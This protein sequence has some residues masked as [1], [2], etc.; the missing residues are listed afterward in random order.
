MAIK[1][2]FFFLREFR[3]T[4][5]RGH[6]VISKTLT[7][8]NKKLFRTVCVRTSLSLLQPVLRV[9]KLNTYLG[10]L[11]ALFNQSLLLRQFGKTLLWIH[12]WITYISR[13]KCYYGYRASILNGSTLE[14][15]LLIFRLLRLQSFS[16]TSFANFMVTPEALSRF[17]TQF[18]SVN[19]DRLYFT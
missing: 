7:H 6:A 8:L 1:P 3:S 15:Y 16:R 9:N 14:L 19:F 2:S 18:L 4:P 5:L 10:F 13:T 12:H 17:G 11:L